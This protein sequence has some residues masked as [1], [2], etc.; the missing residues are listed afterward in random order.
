MKSVD[1]GW[2]EYQIYRCDYINDAKKLLD[3]ASEDLSIL[4]SDFCDLTIFVQRLIDE[5]NL[6]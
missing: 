3:V 1:Y 6:M 4:A 5:G 2:Y